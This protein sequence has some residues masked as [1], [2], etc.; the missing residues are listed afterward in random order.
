MNILVIRFRQMGDAILSTVVLNSLKK[1]FPECKIDYVL[2]ENLCD[3][4]RGHPSIDRLIPFSYEECHNIWKYIHKVYSI[5]HSTHYDV[6]ID[7]RGTPKTTLF[8]LF[9]LSTK[10]RIGLK[11]KYTK[12]AFNYLVEKCRHDQSMIDH[13]LCRV[14]PLA[15]EGKLILDPH[16]TLFITSEEQKT[17]DQYLQAKGIDLTKPILLAGVTA[18]LA[19]KA[20]NEDRMAW[21][22]EKFIEAYPDV[23]IIF[24][25]APGKEKENAYRIYEELGKPQQVHIEVE[26][27]SQRE[28]VALSN[29]ITMYF[30]N[31]GGARHIVHACGK[32]S[33]VVVCP[34][35]DK[36]VWLPKNDVPTDGIAYT[37][38]V[39]GQ[40][41]TTLDREA[42]YDLITK[43]EVWRR[44]SQFIKQHH[45][46]KYMRF[47]HC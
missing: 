15:P 8:A 22:I 17:Y 45:I 30:G 33:Y 5:V 44:C 24:N 23:Q 4:F 9:S 46:F 2:N 7:M 21:V 13:H 16:F 39:G 1:S 31:E 11:K 42:K 37:D 20:W 25:Y 32:P 34:T 41:T 14:K 36:A 27:K 28:L 38:L 10:Y 35:T 6:I 40:D 3:L 12:F 47:A 43:E 18:K 19:G 26:A 29:R